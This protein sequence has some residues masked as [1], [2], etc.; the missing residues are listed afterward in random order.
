MIWLYLDPGLG[1]L[2][3]QLLW[4]CT[5]CGIPAAILAAIVAFFR[6]RRKKTKI[7]VGSEN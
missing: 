3:I 2:L 4:G 7:S 6:N 5:L 1:S